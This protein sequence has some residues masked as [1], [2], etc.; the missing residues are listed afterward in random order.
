[1]KLLIEANADVNAP[2]RTNQN[3][4]ID[5]TLNGHYEV[6]KLLIEHGADVNARK[7]TY[8][9]VE[10]PLMYTVQYKRLDIAKLLIDNG[11]NV[12]AKNHIDWTPIISATA[13]G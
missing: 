7:G 3:A 11:A 1:M 8:N 10:I 12:N 13:N 5:A 4:L 9:T 6:V 2:S